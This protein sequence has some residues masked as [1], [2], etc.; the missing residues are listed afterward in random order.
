MIGYVSQFVFLSDTTIA[1][2]I[3]F[4][5]TKNKIDYKQLDKVIKITQLKSFI[6]EL[7]NG[8][9]T[10]VGENGVQ[11]SGGQKQRIG[12]ARALYREPDILVFDEATSSLDR[13]TEIEVMKS[14]YSLKGEKTIVIVAHR[15]STL[16]QCDYIYKV[17]SGNLI[18]D[19]DHS[20]WF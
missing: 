10:M 4:G 20:I 8:I 6:D 19:Y 16:D 9:E 15:L 2:N 3:A 18:L 14:I 5:F 1:E 12:I 17:K 7:P 11:L 13:S